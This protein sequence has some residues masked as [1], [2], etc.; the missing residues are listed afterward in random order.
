MSGEGGVSSSMPMENDLMTDDHSLPLTLFREGRLDAAIEAA[1]D[2]VRRQP[3][4]ATLRIALAEYLT[5]ASALERADTVLSAAEAVGVEFAVVISEFRQLLR[6]ASSRH[7]LA[8]EGRPPEFIH[9]PTEAQTALLRGSVALRAGDREEAAR[10]A[11]EAEAARRPLPG[12][13]SGRA[14][15]DFRD[16]DDLIGS[17]LEVLTTTGRFFWIDAADVLSLTLHEP[18]RPRDLIWRRC[19]MSVRNGPDGD[20]YLPALY[21]H[22]GETEDAFRLGRSTEWGD[23]EPIR[24]RGQRVFLLG[25]DGV[26]L[27]ELGNVEFAS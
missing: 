8:A 14:F 16:A 12:L 23:E 24:G 26:P 15:D 21:D 9:D 2:L 4:D 10:A 18:V 3:G 27:H 17:N 13:R 22:P 19:T 25:E 7:L 1:S 11:A 6:A 20:V 5:F